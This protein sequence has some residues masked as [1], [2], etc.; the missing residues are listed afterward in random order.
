LGKCNSNFSSISGF[1][2]SADF[3]SDLIQK[4]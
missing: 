1:R 3:I 2:N 4:S